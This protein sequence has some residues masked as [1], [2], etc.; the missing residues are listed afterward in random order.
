MIQAEKIKYL[1]FADQFY[2]IT[3]TSNELL[4]VKMY[5]FIAIVL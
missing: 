4:V 5:E 3:V 1:V 2:L